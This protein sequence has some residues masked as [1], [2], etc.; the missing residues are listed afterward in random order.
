MTG[1][2]SRDKGRRTELGIVRLLQDAGF[3]AEKISRTGYTGGDVSVPLLGIDRIVEIKIRGAGFKQLY[4]WLAGRDLLVVRSD[5]AEPLVI[6]PL[7]LAAEI[8]RAAERGK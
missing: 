3:A 5:R 2:R 4:R 6:L 8:A 1:R 7:K